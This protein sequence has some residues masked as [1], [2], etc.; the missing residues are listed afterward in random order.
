MS[1]AAIERDRPEIDTFEDL[2]RSLG[3]VPLSRIRWRPHPV[4]GTARVWTAV[5]QSSQ[6]PASGSPESS[7]VL[8]GFVLPLAE[9][10][11]VIDRTG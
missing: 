11:E 6:L 2:Q 8:P 5:D 9:L 7:D 4:S 10:F 1:A 3:G